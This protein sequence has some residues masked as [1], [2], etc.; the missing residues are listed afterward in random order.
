MNQSAS[1]QLFSQQGAHVE[2]MTQGL[3]LFNQGNYHGAE[4]KFAT[5]LSGRPEDPDILNYQAA[6]KIRL[7][8]IDESI[9]LATKAIT[10]KNSE[11]IFYNTLGTAY[12]CLGKLDEARQAL[13]QCVA[14]GNYNWEARVNLGRVHFD[15]QSFEEAIKQFEFAMNLRDDVSYVYKYLADAYRAVGRFVEAEE[16]YRAYLKTDEADG[17]AQNNFGYVLEANKKWEEAVLHYKRAVE[18][19]PDN[20]QICRNYGAILNFLDRGDEA[21]E[22]YRMALAADPKSPWLYSDIIQ[23][24]SRRHDIDKAYLYAKTMETLPDYDPVAH[25]MGDRMASTVCDFEAE[26][27]INARR[28]ERY[29]KLP[30]GALAPLFLTEIKYCKD[31]ATTLWLTDLHRKW[32]EWSADKAAKDPNPINIPLVHKHKGR[33]RIRIGIL[34]SDLRTHV[35][36]KFLMPLLQNYDKSE[37]EIICYSIYRLED[38]YHQKKIRALVDRFDYIDDLYD[39]EIVEHVRKDELDILFELNG[40]TADNRMTTISYKMAPVQIGWLGYPITWGQKELN[41]AMVDR[42]TQPENHKT[43]VEELLIMPNCYLCYALGI[44]AEPDVDPVPAFERNK[45]ISFG[46]FNNPLKY[47]PECIYLWANVLLQVPDS[48]FVFVR[49]EAHSLLLQQNLTN[50]FMKYGIDQSRIAF[51]RNAGGSHLPYYGE[52]DISLDV[53]PLTGG[54]TTCESMSM[55]VPV[56]TRYGPFTHQRLSRTFISNAGLPELCADNDESFVEIAA[57]LAADT[58]LLKQLH[59][60]LR[61]IMGSSALCNEQAFARDFEE[62]MRQ[63]VQHH[64]LR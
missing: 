34:S 21:I 10:L 31:E 58:G 30:I 51:I 12:L 53:V 60:N 4:E 15:Q 28:L 6:T 17:E 61:G 48:R 19:C 11:P 25:A 57:N 9:E 47:T 7:G 46:T 56:V 52:L 42:F 13:E 29:E 54:T 64:G 63:V 49:P 41:Y 33:K 43:Y 3:A 44:S 27:R 37:L 38:D 40:H 26:A 2:L 18:L 36:A 20:A 16:K 8:K 24:L 39:H 59:L 62:A 5:Y 23:L 50:E 1:W 35:V 14:L 45:M 55:G 32:G 22:A